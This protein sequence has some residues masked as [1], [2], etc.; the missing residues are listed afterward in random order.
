MRQW[1]PLLSLL[2]HQ[3]YVEVIDQLATP[4]LHPL[5]AKTA[6]LV[7]DY[8]SVAFEIAYIEK[9]VIYY[10]FDAEQFYGGGHLGFAGYFDFARDGFGPICE[11]E[12]NLFR[13]LKASLSGNEPSH[14][15]PSGDVQHFLIGMANAAIA[16]MRA[17]W[18][19]MRPWKMPMAA[20]HTRRRQPTTLPRVARA[21]ALN[22]SGGTSRQFCD[23]ETNDSYG[24]LRFV[25][26]RRTLHLGNSMR[27]GLV[28]KR[29]NYYAKPERCVLLTTATSIG[30]PLKQPPL[31]RY[32]A[33]GS[34]QGQLYIAPKAS[35]RRRS[36]RRTA[37]R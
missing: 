33:Q 17:S 7:T 31:H 9:P 28:V 3:D 1:H 30:M 23:V 11:T 27:N 5:F 22:R 12:V 6:L 13:C 37:P 10:Q 16:R 8:S 29:F 18:N 19:W 15:S 25:F 24:R 4:S 20:S 21:I 2:R 14:I 35:S 26:E 32:A 34:S 36:P